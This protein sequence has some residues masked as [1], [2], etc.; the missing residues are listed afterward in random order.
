VYHPIE[1]SQR[2]MA[3]LAPGR[4]EIDDNRPAQVDGLAVQI[5]QIE[6]RSRISDARAR[7]G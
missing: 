1:R 6:R 5:A 4:R 7:R 3:R 2:K